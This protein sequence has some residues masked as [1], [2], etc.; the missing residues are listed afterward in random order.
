VVIR[1]PNW[2]KKSHPFAVHYQALYLA[3][4]PKKGIN[5]MAL[6]ES[7]EPQALFG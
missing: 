5:R 1:R 6:V 7:T 4:N 2:H 3:M